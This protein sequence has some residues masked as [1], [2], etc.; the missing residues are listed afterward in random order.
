MS[1][2]LSFA[3]T[4]KAKGQLVEE[5]TSYPNLY[6][7]EPCMIQVYLKLK[8]LVQFKKLRIILRLCI[9]TIPQNYNVTFLRLISYVF[10]AFQGIYLN[11][12]YLFFNE[13]ISIKYETHF[14]PISF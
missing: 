9:S 3:E 10:L 1:S 5:T 7:F 12:F 8:N 11:G 4:L 6:I 2:A 14:I 13:Q